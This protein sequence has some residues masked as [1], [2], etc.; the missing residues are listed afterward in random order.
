MSIVTFGLGATSSP[1]PTP[2]PTGIDPLLDE[3][4][5]P[6]LDEAGNDLL[7]EDS[8][9]ASA[10]PDAT[11]AQPQTLLCTDEDILVHAGGTDYG[12]LCPAYQQAAAGADGVFA[13]GSPWVLT[14]A[15]ID[16]AAYGVT[17]NSV[18]QLTT[19]K[20]NFGTAGHW[21]AVNDVTGGSMTLR[22]PYKG[23]GIGQPPAPAAGLTAVTFSVLTFGPQIAEATYELYQRFGLDERISAVG[24]FRSPQWVYDLQVLRVA[25]VYS[26]LWAM[27]TQNARTNKGDFDN[28]VDRFKAMMDDAIGRCTVRWG[29]VG[30]S[31]ESTGIFSTRVVR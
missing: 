18:V 13:A 23:L 12:L 8:M 3:A 11:P 20:A 30:N 4:G 6:L 24:M 2:T 17:P 10:A 14:S 29:P 15:T 21:L 9:T 27:Y 31:Q 26:V 16:F 7:A 22:R 1:T 25:C 28:K 5:N 19:P